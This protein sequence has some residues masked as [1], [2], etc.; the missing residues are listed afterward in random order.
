MWT[1]IYKIIGKEV[2]KDIGLQEGTM[3]DSTPWYKSKAKLAAIIGAIVAAI[4]PISAAVGHPIVI[5][6]WVLQIL[7]A[8]G[9]YGIR[10]SIKS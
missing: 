6:N 8:I 2:V 10:D 1:W 7:G 9:L 5:P 3:E 4:G